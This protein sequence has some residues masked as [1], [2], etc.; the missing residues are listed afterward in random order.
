MDDGTGPSAAVV[1]PL[2][3]LFLLMPPMIVLFARE[4]DFFGVPLIVFYVF[5]VW[6]ALIA[7]TAW[8]AQR[9]DPERQSGSAGENEPH[10]PDPS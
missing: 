6:V 7:C 2:L 1:L 9:L 5:G 8:L 10:T 4:V 3:G